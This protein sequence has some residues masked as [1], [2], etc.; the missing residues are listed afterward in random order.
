[1]TDDRRS[2]RAPKAR[3]AGRLAILSIG[4]CVL[5]IAALS[6][7]PGFAVDVGGK[8]PDFRLPQ[9]GKDAQLGLN[10][11]H[12]K[13]VLVDFWASWCGPCR[14]S[15]PQY[16]KLYTSLSRRDFE[17]VAVNLDED[18]ADAK[19][20][21]AAHPVTYPIVLDPAGDA[22]RREGAAGADGEAQRRRVRCEPT[23][24]HPG[25]RTIDHGDASA[26]LV[27]DPDPA[28]AGD[29]RDGGALRGLHQCVRGPLDLLSIVGGH[30]SLMCALGNAIEIGSV[31]VENLC[32][33]ECLGCLWGELAFV[34][35]T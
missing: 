30:P 9:L 18:L 23:P 14:E 6:A 35:W 10:D 33:R 3:P 7:L 34:A 29:D 11:V 5:A 26:A 20:F 28:A 1:M 24:D 16:E 17:I 21:L 19:K 13:V 27:G 8:A 32:A 22:E 4:R 2:R 15:L 25:A 12:G 31:A